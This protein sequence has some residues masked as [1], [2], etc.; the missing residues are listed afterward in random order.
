MK[1]YSIKLIVCALTVGATTAFFSTLKVSRQGVSCRQHSWVDSD[2]YNSQNDVTS[3]PLHDKG[4]RSSA[5]FPD[6]EQFSAS[7]FNRAKIPPS[8]Y[9][10]IIAKEHAAAR[11]KIAAEMTAAQ[12]S[13][14]TEY[15][16]AQTD[17]DSSVKSDA[18]AAPVMP[19]V[20]AVSSAAQVDLEQRVQAL[21]EN[22]EELKTALTHI[23]SILEKQSSS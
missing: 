18:A 13:S 3:R 8:E 14:T 16:P 20:R 5:Y 9:A 22:M 21:E 11:A 2:F 17:T 12:V 7:V 19:K 6:Q 10:K 23:L 4:E 1:Y 15:M